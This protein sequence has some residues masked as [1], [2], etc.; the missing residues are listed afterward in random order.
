VKN[1]CQ[2]D[3]KKEMTFSPEFKF[4]VTQLVI[5]QQYSIGAAC[6]A[7]A[8]SKSSMENWVRQLRQEQLKKTPKAK[9]M[10]PDQRRIQALKKP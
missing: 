9:A 10:T 5:D 8:G 3:K 6:E 7:I 4:D 1:R 2:I